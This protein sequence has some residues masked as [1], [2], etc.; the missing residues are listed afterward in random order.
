L[1]DDELIVIWKNK[2]ISKEKIQKKELTFFKRLILWFKNLF[3]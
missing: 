2:K 3:K 1:E